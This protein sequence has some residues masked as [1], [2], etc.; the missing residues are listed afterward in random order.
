MLINGRTM[1]MHEVEI[2]SILA[3]VCLISYHLARSVA[4]GCYK[5]LEL[6]RILFAGKNEVSS[7]PVD[8]DG[9][10]HWSLASFRHFAF[11][12]HKTDVKSGL[13][14]APNLMINKLLGRSQ[15]CWTDRSHL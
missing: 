7:L 14:N 6:I 11:S 10:F 2:P 15:I 3:V 5:P 1:V 9:H 4:F 8:D 13:H 12:A